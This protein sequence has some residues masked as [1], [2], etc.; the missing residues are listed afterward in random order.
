MFLLTGIIL[1]VGAAF[2][3]AFAKTEVEPWAQPEASK[4]LEV[5]LLDKINIQ[6]GLTEPLIP[7]KEQ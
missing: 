1:V 2:F 6:K 3:V 4:P 5:I 7:L